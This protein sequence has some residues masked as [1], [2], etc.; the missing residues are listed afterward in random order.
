[1]F[2]DFFV[3]RSKAARNLHVHTIT[4]AKSKKDHDVT[5]QARF[6]KNFVVKFS[7]FF[8]ENFIRKFLIENFKNHEKPVDLTNV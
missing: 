6:L 4:N 2:R 5:V 7:R 1:M 8:F 3:A